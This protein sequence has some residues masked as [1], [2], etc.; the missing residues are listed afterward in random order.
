MSLTEFEKNLQ[1]LI[2]QTCQF[3]PKT[4]ERQRGLTQIY[5]VIQKSGKLWQ[6]NTSYYADAWQKSWL[7]FCLNLCESVT[8]KCYNSE[9]SS[10][11]TWLNN[12]L[13]W[14]LHNE[15]SKIEQQANRMISNE[16]LFENQF[17]NI[18]ETLK[19]PEDVPP[20]LETVRKWAES[21]VTGELCNHHIRGRKDVTCQLLILRRLPPET[22]W[23]DLSQELGLPVSTLSSFYERNC[24]KYLRKFG[25]AEGY[26]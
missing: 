8:G 25:E 19:A 10:V 3:P 12:H 6:E 22:N 16:I 24:T 11:I 14:V 4:V 23:K 2:A 9:L 26:L 13:K 7:F 20:M 15:K 1:Q 5:R 18:L 21:D 17:I